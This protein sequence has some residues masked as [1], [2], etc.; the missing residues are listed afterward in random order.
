M[1]AAAVTEDGIPRGEV[2]ICLTAVKK[3]IQDIRP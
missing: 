3:N 1:L 2:A